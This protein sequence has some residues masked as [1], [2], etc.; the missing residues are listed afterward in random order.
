MTNRLLN[1]FRYGKGLAKSFAHDFGVA[2]KKSHADL[3]FISW[4]KGEA[5]AKE[6]MLKRVWQTIEPHIVPIEKVTEHAKYKE[7]V[8]AVE[9]LAPKAGI[10]TPEIFVIRGKNFIK[11]VRNKGIVISEDELAKN[12]IPELRALMGHELKHIAHGDTERLFGSRNQQI[13]RTAD[14]FSARLTGDPESLMSAISK[15]GDENIRGNRLYP[16]IRSR[17]LHLQKIARGEQTAAMTH[18]ERVEAERA[19][20]AVRPKHLH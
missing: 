12:T 18:V 3:R 4:W 19:I 9:E 5:V 1:M 7:L 6:I 8:K 16:S 13:E 14:A 20:S 10:K 15:M 17:I 11:A 2:F